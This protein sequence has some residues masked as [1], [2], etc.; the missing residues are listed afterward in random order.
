MK[1]ISIIAIF[2]FIMSQRGGMMERTERYIE[3]RDGHEAYVVT[4]KPDKR[5]RGYVHLCHG[6]A[7][8]SGRYDRFCR[9]LAR[10]GYFVSIH[11]HRGHG[12]SVK[13]GGTYGYF[14][15]VDGFGRVV[16]DLHEILTTLRL[17]HGLP[18]PIVF[19][20]SMGSFITRRY[21]QL[22]S[23]A[24]EA[25]ILSGSG[26]A[27]ALHVTGHQLAKVFVKTHG[28]KAEAHLMS[29][30]S[31]GSFNKK[32]PGA[33]TAFDWL[34]RDN[35]SV[36]SYMDDPLCGFVATNQFFVDLTGGLLLISKDREVAKIRK[37]LPVLFIS[38]NKDPVGGDNAS[39]V[40]AAAAQMEKQGM[41]RV[42]VFIFENMR[43]EVLNEQNKEY[44]YEV[45]TRWL[46]NEQKI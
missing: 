21:I 12:R 38:G 27:N 34:T 10:I 46:K 43:H 2:L 40:L 32:F 1:L 13:E 35:D 11:D 6:M 39:G 18:R 24:V 26:V 29:E 17:E 33:R 19:G 3:M 30:L 22:Y 37:D 14:A 25:V 15:D 41:E 45:I 20:H 31:F 9:I 16:E 42:A 4:Y 28:A 5:M 7:E 36:Q 8:H 23:E 44:V